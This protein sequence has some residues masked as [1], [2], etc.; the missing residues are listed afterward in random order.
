M[1]LPSIGTGYQYTDGNIGE[2]NIY[3]QGD[4]ATA[5]G[6]VTLTAAQLLTGL[7]V[8]NPGASAAN[9]TLPTVAQL[10]AALGGNT[11]KVNTTFEV[12]FVNL[13]TTSG[14]VTF[15]AGT[16]WTL[17]GRAAVPITTGATLIARKTGAGTWT[18]YIVG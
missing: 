17:V 9:Y 7:L 5:T 8:G 16:G 2:V 14:V 3:A 11:P 15:V 12:R 4:P 1:P 13:G 18:L 10:E 6:T